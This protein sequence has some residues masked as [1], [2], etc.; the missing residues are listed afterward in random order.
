MRS[1]FHG[2][3]TA[4]R[5]LYA[6]QYAL[7]TTGHN[8]ANAETKGYSRQRVNM[9]T[10]HPID[11]VA[12]NRS[13]APGQLGTGVIVE[14]IMRMRDVF[15]DSQFRNEHQRL[16][17]WEIR[18]DVL[19]KLEVIANE[20]S[21][22]GL[23]ALI[24]EFW[25][26]WETLSADPGNHAVRAPV[27]ETMKTLVQ[28]F[29]TKARQLSDLQEDLDANLDIQY[30]RA[31]VL[32]D[33][34]SELNGQIAKVE[35]TGD[36]A[37]DLRDRRDLLVDE[38]SKLADIHAWEEVEN[39]E[40]VY[41]VALASASPDETDEDNVLPAHIL[42]S[43][44][45]KNEL[46]R[47]REDQEIGGGIIGGLLRSQET[48]EQYANELDTMVDTF[49]RGE[50]EVTLP[51]G[52]QTVQGVNGLHQLGWNGNGGRGGPLFVTSDGSEPFT[53]ANIRVADITTDDLAPSHREDAP[54]SNGIA[55]AMA[56]LGE[57]GIFE[58]NSGPATIE[59]GT[60]GQYYSAYVANLG[61][62]T[63]RAEMEY[64]NQNTVLMSIDQRRQSISAVSLDEEMVNMIQFQH[65]Y[66][67]AARNMTAIDEILDRVINGMGRVGR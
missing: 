20:P 28:A 60:I 17:E 49:V 26:A 16:G 40:L 8:V 24:D 6:Q 54:G 37:N 46:E 41:K 18:L 30:G 27:I 13:A 31:N 14:D 48:V 67:A 55:R 64:N 66:N 65:A 63:E 15:L 2:L 42:V 52:P 10:A 58:F 62:E 47:G 38:L 22:M 23:G 43:G 35:K 25:N 57:E 12:V 32:I 5:A 34:I 4:R 3:E 53:A 51:E 11:P 50:V 9:G 7:Y 39:G 33:Q 36:N 45:E 44:T 56:R 29:N 59:R 21:E 1:T 19:D 61:V